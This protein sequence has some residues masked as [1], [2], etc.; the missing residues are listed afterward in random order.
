MGN[1]RRERDSN[2][3]YRFCPY[4]PLAGAR[5]RPLGH[6][7]GNSDFVGLASYPSLVVSPA[8]TL[9]SASCS[10]LGPVR[11]SC[12]PARRHA[13]SPVRAY[14]P[15]ART[16]SAISPDGLPRGLRTALPRSGAMIP[17]GAGPV[18]ETLFG[19]PGHGQAGEDHPARARARTARVRSCRL[20]AVLRLRPAR[21]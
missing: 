12:P 3:R 19:V 1:W 11:A 17:A 21:A 13:S 20:P 18:K 7:S 6:L 16:H 14:G 15:V 9:S 5:L 10:A 4:T 2:P 8:R